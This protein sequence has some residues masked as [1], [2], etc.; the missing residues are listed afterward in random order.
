MAVLTI[1]TATHNVGRVNRQ[2]LVQEHYEE[3]TRI[4]TGVESSNY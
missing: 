3:T 1:L 4:T 2:A